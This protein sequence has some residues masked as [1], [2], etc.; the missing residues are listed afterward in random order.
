VSKIQTNSNELFQV[1]SA[2]LLKGEDPGR[3]KKK[4]QT[5]NTSD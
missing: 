4:E 2:R 3:R 1:Y 5:K